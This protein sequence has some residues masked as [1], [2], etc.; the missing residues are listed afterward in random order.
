MD[1]SSGHQTTQHFAHFASSGKGSQE[2][3]NL[4]HARRNH[5]LQIDRSQ[6]RDRRHLRRRRSLGNRLLVAKAQELPLGRFTR[7]RDNWNDP[8]L[9]P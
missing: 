4:F 3:L 9:L 6:H 5:S 8:Q 1:L 7:R 2:Q